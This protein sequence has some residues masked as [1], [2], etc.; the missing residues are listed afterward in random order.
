PASISPAGG[1][2]SRTS[3]RVAMVCSGR[4]EVQ[5]EEEGQVVGHGRR[6]VAV[7]QRNGAALGGDVE[8]VEYESLN[9]VRTHQHLIEHVPEERDRVTLGAVERLYYRRW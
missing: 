1:T 2:T 3:R 9:G 5:L 7:D 8:L 4:I 6:A